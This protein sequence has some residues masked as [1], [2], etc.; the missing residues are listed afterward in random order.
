MGA[1]TSVAESVFSFFGF[2]TT[3]ARSPKETDM[4]CLVGKLFPSRVVVSLEL[5]PSSEEI[6]TAAANGIECL[7]G[8]GHSRA[9]VSC[10]CG[11]RGTQEMAQAEGFDAPHQP[12][13]LFVF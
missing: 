13:P 1:K 7:R 2:E 12:H 10:S 6:Q 3:A 11:L 5:L 4:S 8:M 9:P